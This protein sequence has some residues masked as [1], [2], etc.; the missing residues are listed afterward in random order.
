MVSE[1]LFSVGTG[2]IGSLMVVGFL[3]L[4]RPSIDISPFIAEQGA[5]NDKTFGF[6]IIN[7]TPYP[8]VD[9]SAELVLVTPKN[10]P[11]GTVHAGREIPL[12]RSRFFELDKFDAKD[13]DAN[14]ALRIGCGED[15]RRLWQSDEQLLRLSIIAKHSFSGFSKVVSKNFH[16]KGDIKSG[17]HRAGNSLEVDVVN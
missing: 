16:T 5:G 7:R 11:G 17:K 9:I 3:Y 14:Y 12:L 6:K 10:V 13:K 4:L 2:F 1:I 8:I 15:I